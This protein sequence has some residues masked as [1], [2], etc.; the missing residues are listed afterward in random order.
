MDLQQQKLL[1]HLTISNLLVKSDNTAEN[2]LLFDKAKEKLK[3][4]LNL[5]NLKSANLQLAS[6]GFSKSLKQ[7]LHESN[8][9]QFESD[10]EDKEE[11]IH[12]TAVQ[13]NDCDETELHTEIRQ[14]KLEK[15]QLEVQNERL[16]DHAQKLEVK[17]EELNRKQHRQQKIIEEAVERRMAI[18]KVHQLKDCNT[19]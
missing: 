4:F 11:V 19:N 18:L 15:H 6:L 9:Y 14:L 13:N 16:V 10:N 8:P 7:L 2:R 17:L 5:H 12:M 3:K 1:D